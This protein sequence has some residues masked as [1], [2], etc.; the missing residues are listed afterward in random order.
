[1]RAR[2]R[3]ALIG[4]AAGVLALAAPAGAAPRPESGLGMPRDVSV[5]GHLIDW[6]I[7]ITSV[8]VLILFVIAVIW[9]LY[10]ALR[11]G[12]RHQAVYDHGSAR[13]SITV[14]L[15]ISAVIFFVVDGNLF[16]NAVKDLRDAFWNFAGA[17]RTP[18]AVRIEVNAHQWAWDARYPGL[19][20]KFNTDDDIVVLNDIRVPAGVPVVMQLASTDVIHSLYLP[21]FRVKQ[22]AVPGQVN[23]I[24]FEARPEVRGE[25]D[26]GCAQ[27][28]GPNHYKMKG[29]L[30]VMSP[31]EYQAWYREASADGRRG[32]D[33]ADEEAHWGWEWR[34]I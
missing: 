31:A 22:D 16:I 6:L 19:D 1:M 9:M 15:G 7:D 25:F 21:N 3:L 10:A 13:H 12:P 2:A 8:F 34:R 23:R 17:E 14:A 4:A 26:I 33:P 30:I 11:H 24:W 20:G 18:G 28:C 29:Q 27:H 5:H 32:Y